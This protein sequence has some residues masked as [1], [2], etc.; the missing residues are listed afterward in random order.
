MALAEKESGVLA[1]SNKRSPNRATARLTCGNES[2]PPDH[3]SRA[4]VE[5]VT[6][7]EVLSPDERIP[8]EPAI[9]TRRPVAHLRAQLSRKLDSHELP[10]ISPP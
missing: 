8:G 3:S 1:S 5:H 9:R 2:F 7:G 4:F 6:L 10:R